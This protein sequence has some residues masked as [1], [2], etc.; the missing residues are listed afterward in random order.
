VLVAAGLLLA[1]ADRTNPA[2]ALFNKLFFQLGPSPGGSATLLELG[3]RPDELRYIGTHT[4]MTGSPA[5]DRPWA[6]TFAKR[7]GYAR[8]MVWYLRNPGR[9]LRLLWDTLAKEA[10]DMRQQNL[11]NFRRQDGHRPG[12]RTSRFAVWSDLRATLTR[13]WPWHMVLWYLLFVVGA[14]LVVRAPRFAA[15]GRLAWVG[16]GIALLGAGQFGVAALADCLETGRHL[17]IFNAC[18][19]LMFCLAVAYLASRRAR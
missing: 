18:T 6:E 12:A 2:Q 19:D 14:I 4:Y 13:R 5:L 1:T 15:E 16:L 10:P 3:V 11:S 17:F 7:T 8:L 9:T